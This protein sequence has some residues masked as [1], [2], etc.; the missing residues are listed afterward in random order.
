MADTL[1]LIFDLDGTLIDSAP[2]I[3]AA[4]N[5]VFQAKGLEPFP[6]AV[7]KGFIGN[8]V[9][10]LVSRLLAAQGLEPTGPLHQDLVAS[11]I[12]LYEEAFDLTAVYPGV[13]DALQALSAQGHRLG[14]C[15]NKPEG[16]ARA[17][18]RHFGLDRDMRVLI[19]GDTLPERKPDPAPLLAA[20]AALGPGPAL[21]LGD[22]EVDAETAHAANVPLALFTEGYRKTPAEAMGAKLIFSDFTALP[23]LISHIAR[24]L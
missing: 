3:H 2:D 16:P 17:A 5:K 1:N 19:G 7:V 23:G 14:I 6:F 11:F 12:S 15:T 22:S 4:A 9:G 21:F 10:V 13:C 8:G 24:R 20:L 18:L